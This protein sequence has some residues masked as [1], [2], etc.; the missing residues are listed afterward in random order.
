MNT[1]QLECGKCRAALSLPLP[2]AAV[3]TLCPAC[4]TDLQAEIFPAL[5]RGSTRGQRAESIL[6][7]DESSC[8]YH[9]TKKASLPCDA[10]GRFLCSVCDIEIEGQHLCPGCIEKGIKK[11]SL[12]RLQNDT[13]RYDDIALTLAVAPLLIFYITLFTA[14]AA[15]FI[16]L[17]NWK[18]PVSIVSTNRWR[19]VVAI[20]FS[21]LQIAAWGI[22]AIALLRYVFS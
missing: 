5:F 2:E 8:F 14:P 12:E 11:G 21:G 6:V 9:P 10:C 20:I 17:R 7:D 4:A 18:K 16:A 19:L 3:H 1:L 15:L 22:G 13:T